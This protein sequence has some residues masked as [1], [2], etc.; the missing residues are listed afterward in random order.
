[1]KTLSLQ[2]E[3]NDRLARLEAEQKKMAEETAAMQKK[4]TEERGMY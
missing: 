1:M 2:Q 3:A 4:V